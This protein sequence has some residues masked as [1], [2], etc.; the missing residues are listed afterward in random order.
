MNAWEVFGHSGHVGL[1][2][3]LVKSAHDDVQCHKEG[4]E[5]EVLWPEVLRTRYESMAV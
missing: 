4:F 3:A 1:D 5:T 2:V